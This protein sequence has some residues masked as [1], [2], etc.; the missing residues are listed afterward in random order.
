MIDVQLSQNWLE[1]SSDSALEECKSTFAEV[2]NSLPEDRHAS[3]QR[4]SVSNVSEGDVAYLIYDER[5]IATFQNTHGAL[6]FQAEDGAPRQDDILY[7]LRYVAKLLSLAVYSRSHEGARLPQDYTLSLD[8]SLFQHNKSLRDFFAGSKFIPRYA[9]EG[10]E[11]VDDDR[12]A[13][14]IYS[15]YYC[16]HKGDGSIHIINNTML[17]FLTRKDDQRTSKEFS[18]KVADS[19]NDFAQKFDLGLIPRSFYQ[20]YGTSTKLINDTYFDIHHINR[21]VFINP[22]VWNFDDEHDQRF[23][24]N[25]E[26]GLH[27]MDKVRKGETV[28]TAIKRVLR[29]ELKVADDYVGARV[30]GL[31]FDRDREGLLTPRLN[32][33]IFVHG[34]TKHQRG[35]DHDWVSLK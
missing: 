7:A 32:M 15:P 17:D 18:Y 31:E 2:L 8:H 13:L 19:M 22:F 25:T 16:Q 33:H 28:D 1:Q 29:E 27:L 24:A 21:K 3:T 9:P 6:L 10:M 30:W 4:W 11:R 26:N 34:L 35:Q 23:Y 5:P 12:Q 14:V 20:C